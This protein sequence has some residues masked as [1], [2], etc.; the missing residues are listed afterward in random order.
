MATQ[1]PASQKEV[2]EIRKMRQDLLH[3]KI[4]LVISAIS[5]FVVLIAIG[6]ERWA[7][8]TQRDRELQ[9]K[10][11]EQNRE[12]YLALTDATCAVAA[13][14]NYKQVEEAS[15][16]FNKIYYGRAHI[17]ADYKSGDAETNAQR[18]AV[19]DAKI[20][21]HDALKKYLD[22]KPSEPPEGYFNLLAMD[23]TAACKPH[24]DPHS[25]NNPS[26]VKRMDPAAE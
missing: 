11:F 2:L 6:I 13:C 10:V 15:N 24:I 12:H 19:F 20:K 21:F 4:S 3:G 17:F 8:Y 22:E 14:R 26:P 9:L 25:M 5:I 1:S 7:A 23:V 18:K 16:Q